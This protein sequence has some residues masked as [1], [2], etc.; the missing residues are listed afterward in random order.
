MHKITDPIP[1]AHAVHTGCAAPLARTRVD[2]T[3]DAVAGATARRQ[4]RPLRWRREALADLPIWGC[5]VVTGKP[6]LPALLL[7]VWLPK[8]AQTWEWEVIDPRSDTSMAEGGSDSQALAQA[9]AEA[10]TRLRF[11][12][13]LERG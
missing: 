6:E 9:A 7:A 5:D 1:S 3:P 13:V 2:A 8:R 11:G 10:W 12:D 4:P